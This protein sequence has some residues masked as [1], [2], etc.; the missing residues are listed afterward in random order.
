MNQASQNTSQP[1]GKG[2]LAAYALPSIPMAAVG[3]PLLVHIPPFYVSQM[4]LSLELVGFL[5]MI[6]RFWDVFTDPV[7]GILSDRFETKWGRRRHWMVASVPILM[8]SV[9]MLFWPPQGVSGFYMAFWLF[10]LYAGWTLLT[11]SHS[12]WGAELTG[13]YHERNKVSGAREIAGVSGVIIVLV[14]PIFIDF[15]VEEDIEAKR[16]QIMGLFMMVL[17]PIAIYIAVTRVPERKTPPPAHITFR[18]AIKALIGNKPLR[19]IL[20][21]DILLGISF[22]MHSGTFLFLVTHVLKLG[23]MSGIFLLVYVGSGIA[24]IPIVL[25]ISQK[26]DKHRTAS[27]L[28]L[29]G[30]ASVVPILLLPPGN[31]PLALICFTLFG[32]TSSSSSFIFRSM[33]ADVADQDAVETGQQRTGLYYSVVSMTSK[34][35]GAIAIWISYTALA[36]IGFNATGDNTPEALTGLRYIYAFPTVISCTLA[37]LFFKFYTLTEEVQVQNRVILEARAVHAM[38]EGLEDLTHEPADVDVGQR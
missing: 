24:F 13:D 34:V 8:I 37:Y 11:I 35:G 26:W 23:N 21:A 31:V 2:K 5:F 4:G 25:K 38:A 3:L 32:V 20:A 9:Y 14:L 30:A 22:G 28:M 6:A 1:L 16:I 7:L 19:I 17:L 15:F 10:A 36:L 27:G 29:L 33:V 18:A 12:S